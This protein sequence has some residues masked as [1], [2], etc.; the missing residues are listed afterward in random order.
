[1]VHYIVIILIYLAMDG[2]NFYLE[3]ILLGKSLDM[4]GQALP[5]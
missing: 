3:K 4:V 2:G 5:Y 1:M